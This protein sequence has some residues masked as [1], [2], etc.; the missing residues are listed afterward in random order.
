MV[1]KAQYRNISST[2][3]NSF[4]VK[5]L[6]AKEFPAA[7]HF[8]PQ[9]ELSLIVSSIGMRYV[10]NSVK[11]FSEGDLVLIGKNLPHCWKTIGNQK[12]NV[13][14]IVVQWEEDLLGEGWIE[15]EEFKAISKLLKSS[16]LG[17][18]FTQKVA[19]KLE[20]D[21]EELLILSP[22][23][24]LIKFLNILNIL[25]N[26]SHQELLAEPGFRNK[27]SIEDS[28]RI[29]T[30]NNF[31][32]ENYMNK[33]NLKAAAYQISMSEEAFCRFFKNAMDKPF[34]QFVNEYKINMACKMLIDDVSSSVSQIAY[35]CGYNNLSFFY[36]QFRR[37][38]GKSP[39]EFRKMFKEIPCL[40]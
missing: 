39:V 13:R 12:K 11:N 2:P 36:R 25:A 37:F 16:S 8:H 29:S 33:I 35:E 5:L 30:L 15:K 23:K 9:Y 3:G 10:G 40:N 22:F 32:K 4:K 18:K 6:E 19:K 31:V 21:F 14:A 28:E 7:W 26:Q 20:K 17:I 24:K 34:F 27:V 1:L 38:V